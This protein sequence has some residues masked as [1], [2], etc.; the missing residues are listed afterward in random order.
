VREG[1]DTAQICR[2]GHIITTTAASSP[3]FRQKFC[4]ECGAETIMNCDSCGAPIKGFYHVPG[5]I[6]FREPERPPA[7]CH[8]CGRPYPWTERTMAAATE[9][10]D[11]V[12][13]M[14]EQ[15]RKALKDGLTDLV[16]D[17]PRT[18]VAVARLQSWLAK[19]GPRLAASMRELIVDIVAETAKKTLWPHEG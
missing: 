13:S 15:D 1:Y 10:I 14:S 7:F 9:L 18:K 5:V 19:A 4:S 17:T 6:G 11:L 8:A 3:E 12:D 2:N 16:S